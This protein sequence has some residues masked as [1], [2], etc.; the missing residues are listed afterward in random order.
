MSKRSISLS[1]TSRACGG[2]TPNTMSSSMALSI[3]SICMA[4][5]PGAGSRAAWSE[6]GGGPIAEIIN[7]LADK[8]SLGLYARLP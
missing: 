8:S 7:N 1:S 2:M 6:T 4:Y 3:A 5:Q